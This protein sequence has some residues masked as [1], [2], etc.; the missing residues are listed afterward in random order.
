VTAIDIKIVV[1]QNVALCG[2]T[3]RYPWFRAAVPKVG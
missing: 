2:F 1:F 3:D